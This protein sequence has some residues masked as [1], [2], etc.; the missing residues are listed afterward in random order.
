[1]STQT[2]IYGALLSASLVG[3]YLT[4]TSDAEP[5]AGEVVV[6]LDAEAEQIEKIVYSSEALD[7]TITQRSDAAGAYVWVES[8]Q[9]KEKREGPPDDGHGHGHS[10]P[11]DDEPHEGEEHEGGEH[12]G[13]EHEGDAHEG[14]AHEGEGHEEPEAEPVIEVTDKAFKAGRS[15][16]KL[17]EQLAPMEAKCSL[18]EI[19]GD[20]LAE[21]DLAEPEATLTIHRAGKDARTFELGGEAYGTKDRY[22]RETSSGKVYLVDAEMI[23]PLKRGPTSLPDRELLGFQE[24]DLVTLTLKTP[25]GDSLSF[26]RR[27]RDDEEAA[28]WANAGEESRNETAG[29]WLG[30]V[31]RLKSAGYVQP[32]EVPTGLQPA[33][34]LELKAEVDGDDAAAT[35][36]ILSGV[37]ENGDE[38]WFARSS[39]TRE[40]VKLHRSPASQAAEDLET[41][42]EAE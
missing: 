31:F 4:W 38:A 19:S 41:V 29:T 5:E 37:D 23:R 12:E 13:D 2:L 21:L 11:E 35:L 28:Y 27:N 7:M 3:A 10:E 24:A 9:R 20:K 22:L 32:A 8:T 26:D 39:H 17:L 14:D 1:M 15:G 16:D 40:L 30:K 36:E 25:A 18:G 33:F 6:V 42:F 34:G